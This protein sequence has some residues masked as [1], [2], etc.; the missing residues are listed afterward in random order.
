MESCGGR[1][2]ADDGRG[3]NRPFHYLR[4]NLTR[5]G[6]PECVARAVRSPQRNRYTAQTPLRHIQRSEV[7]CVALHKGFPIRGLLE[8]RN[9]CMLRGNPE[10]EREL[11]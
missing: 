7:P 11:L 5:E 2:C 1:C 4:R 10:L 9:G 3:I 6:N 8:N